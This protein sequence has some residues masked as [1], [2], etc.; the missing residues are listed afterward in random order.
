MHSG[1]MVEFQ[2]WKRQQ[3]NSPD[4]LLIVCEGKTEALYFSILKRRFRLP[5]FIKILPELEKKQ[6]QSLGQHE[7]LI[8]KANEKMKEYEA[9]LGDGAIIETWAVC[10]RD[11]YEKSFTHLG[12]FAR[13]RDVSLAFSDPQFENFLLQHFSQDK[14]K[15]S[16]TKVEQELSMKMLQRD[17]KFGL[18]NKADLSWLDEMIDKKHSIVYS[19]IQNADIFSNHTRRPFFT[20][21]KLVY[22]LLQLA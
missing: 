5:T 12:N 14:S 20:V 16:K 10:D 4:L 18:Y 7:K 22:R 3:M 21:Q 1:C 9:E 8:D 11:E 13:E 17:T 2:F 6:Y 19:A 15:N